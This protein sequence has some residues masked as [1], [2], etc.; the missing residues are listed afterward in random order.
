[1]KELLTEDG[2]QEAIRKSCFFLLKKEAQD[3]GKSVIRNVDSIMN[4]EKEV[5]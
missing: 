2:K 4:V 1:M 5:E 3:I